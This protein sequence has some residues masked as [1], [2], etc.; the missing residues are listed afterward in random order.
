[1]QFR[2]ELKV[3]SP[4]TQEVKEHV[5]FEEGTNTHAIDRLVAF[6]VKQGLRVTIEDLEAKTVKEFATRDAVK[7][8]TTC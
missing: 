2:Y 3:F 5:K 8:L 1:M 6:Y 7:G 4:K